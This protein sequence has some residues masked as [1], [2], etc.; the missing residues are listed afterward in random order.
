MAQ[1]AERLREPAPLRAPVNVEIADVLSRL[2]EN[3]RVCDEGWLRGAYDFAEQ[4]HH[5][6]KRR[7]G[8]PYI[9]HPLGVAHMLA[10]LKFDE[11][12]VAVGLLHDVLED[13]GATK[14]DLAARF[15]AEI[16]D[17]VDGVS[18][19]G[20]H[21][22]V[23]SD[24]VQAESFRKLILASA[25]DLRV[26]VVKLVDRL[27]NMLTLG[28]LEVPK[29]R[30][31]SRETLEIYAPLAHRLG[32]SRIQWL[33]EDLA[34]QHMH[35]YR[36]GDLRKQ[37]DE[38]IKGARGTTERVAE[39]LR[40]ALR[41]ADIEC[42]ISH[43]VKG[44]YSI[45]RKLRRRQIDLPELY[46]FLAFRIITVDVKD[47]YAALGVV[48]QRWH[49][50]PGRIK[51]YIAMPKPNGY[52][53]LHTSVVGRG[54]QPFE[55]QIRTRKMDRL[56]EEGVAAHWR[57]KE[58]RPDP[59]P[60]DRQ[61]QGVEEGRRH[62]LDARTGQRGNDAGIAWLRQL[63]E[64]QQETPDP[65][66][67]MDALKIDLYPD[68]VYVFT[69]KGDVLS[70]PRGAT[71]LD[72]AYRIHTELGHHCSGARINGRLMPLRTR[73]NNGD[74]VE[75][76]TNPNRAPSRDWLNI[77][78]TS[79]ARSKIRHWINAEQ[80]KRAIEIGRTLLASELRRYKVSPRRVFESKEMADFVAGEG[81]SGVDELFSRL[82]FGRGSVKPVLRAVLPPERL[83]RRDQPR[84][85]LR[86][87]VSK[88]IPRDQAKLIVK[89]EDDM[90]AFFAGC[91]SPLPGEAI[92]GFVT[93]GRGVSV[94]SVDCPNVRNLLYHPEREIRVEWARRN[95]SMFAVSLVIETRD[96]PGVLAR[97]TEAIAKQ[98]SNIR[99]IESH[100]RGAGE[101]AIDV[102]V[103]VR[104]RKHLNRLQDSL[105]NLSPVRE[106]KRRP[107][108][109]SSAPATA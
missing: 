90:L 17:L 10:E 101:A 3:E 19:I 28:H 67:F 92:I 109:S 48:H 52:Q 75:V 27:H 6:Q 45:Y 7:S 39:Q 102:V 99:H 107:G 50:I 85:R 1:A 57:Y 62:V 93:R 18:K 26:I 51:D 71:P 25:R 76:T 106:V 60:R 56:A 55:V 103:D 32:M 86:R 41:D 42:E 81:Y 34:F 15:G 77:V 38:R 13:T 95:D 65:R 33:L 84:S 37:L 30:R 82:G 58:G 105:E 88:V 4:A 44:Y 61:V 78:A 89:G 69:P 91:C 9:N 98:G 43:R 35:P 16:A 108:S 20:R 49:P 96:R 59:D 87:A 8:E 23:H 11:T 24:E 70:F 79:K 12:S 53:S 94:H 63:L 14:K 47:T 2:Q 21:E 73:L 72:F 68:E 36:Y 104:N 5:G 46:D 83:R 22:Y 29:R 80:K 40:E 54:E 100:S 74:I 97:V 66:S 64:W 31:I